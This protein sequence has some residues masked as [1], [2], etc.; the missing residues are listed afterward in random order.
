MPMNSNYVRAFEYAI[1]SSHW[2]YAASLMADGNIEE[3]HRFLK[4]RR[5]DCTAFKKTILKHTSHDDVLLEEALSRRRSQL[6]TEASIV[7]EGEGD[8]LFDR[9]ASNGGVRRRGPRTDV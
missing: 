3:Y 1:R 6:S 2:D 8:S 9:G 7:E 4:E 5:G